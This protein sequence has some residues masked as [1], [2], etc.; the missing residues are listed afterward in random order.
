MPPHGSERVGSDDEARWP[1]DVPLSYYRERA[2]FRARQS[3]SGV[4]AAVVEFSADGGEHRWCCVVSDG[5]AYR[6]VHVCSNELGP[7][8]RLPPTVVEDAI[9]RFA[10]TLPAPHRL[11]HLVNSNPIH[12]DRDGIARD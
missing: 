12:L 6:Y 11:Y 4:G 3:P 5:S 10:A 1:M 7:W 9:E 8:Q 2:A